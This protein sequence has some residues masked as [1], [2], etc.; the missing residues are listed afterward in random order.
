MHYLCITNETSTLKYVMAT[1]E[2]V[3]EFLKR[4]SF[5]LAEHPM[6]YPFKN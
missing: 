6:S 4:I 2:Q 5:H 3:E 1:K